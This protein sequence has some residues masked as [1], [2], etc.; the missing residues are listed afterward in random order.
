[1][2]R[3]PQSRTSYSDCPESVV[4]LVMLANNYLY[5]IHNYDHSIEECSIDTSKHVVDD[6]QAS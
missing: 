6:Q 3:H 5:F 4:V 1:M 2:L